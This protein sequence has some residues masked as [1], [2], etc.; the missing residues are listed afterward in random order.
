MIRQQSV[1]ANEGITV[2]KS[3]VACRDYDR[4]ILTKAGESVVSS[5]DLS[6]CAKLNLYPSILN[7]DLELLD[8]QRMHFLSSKVCR[9]AEGSGFTEWADAY[10][11]LFDHYRAF[12]VQ[13]HRLGR[14]LMRLSER[15]HCY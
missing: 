1:E 5:L 15:S 3:K 11:I 10:L 6:D 4:D 12:T 8:E 13:F 14:A 2:T 9:R 7:Q